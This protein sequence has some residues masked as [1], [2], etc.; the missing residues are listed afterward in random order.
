MGLQSS[1]LFKELTLSQRKAAITAVTHAFEERLSAPSFIHSLNDLLHTSSSEGDASETYTY[2]VDE[3][4][5]RSREALGVRHDEGDNEAENRPSVQSSALMDKIKQ[6]LFRKRVWKRISLTLSLALLS[7]VVFI[8][9]FALL[10]E[11]TGHKES[12]SKVASSTTLNKQQQPAPDTPNTNKPEIKEVKEPAA[13][14]KE[15]N[16]KVPSLTGLTKEAAEQ[17]ALALGLRYSFYIETNQ[18]AAGTV[19]KQEPQPNEE[20]AKGSRVTF[21]ISKGSVA[22]P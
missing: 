1:P 22:A 3:V 18:L 6:V 14:N 19:F 16:V 15:E 4:V 13:V 20:A 2:D 7:V 11:T 21:W 9:V 5:S 8:G 12:A 17:Q 10:I